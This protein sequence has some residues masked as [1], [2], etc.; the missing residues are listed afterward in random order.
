MIWR[1]ANGQPDAFAPS[2]GGDIAGGGAEGLAGNL[3]PGKVRKQ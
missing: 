2:T 1:L 3:K